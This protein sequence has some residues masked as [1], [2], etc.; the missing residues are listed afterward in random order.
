MTVIT[1]LKHPVFTLQTIFSN[2][3]IQVNPS[4]S[5]LLISVQCLT[6]S[7]SYLASMP[8]SEF[9]TPLSLAAVLANQSH[10]LSS[11]WTSL[12]LICYTYHWWSTQFHPGCHYFSRS[13]FLLLLPSSTFTESIS[14]NMSITPNHLFLISPSNYTHELNNLISGTDALHV[15][16]YKMALS[17]SLAV[18]CL[19]DNIKVLHLVFL[20]YPILSFGQGSSLLWTHTL[21]P[22]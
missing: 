15:W 1:P 4:L 19:A 22:L 7:S 6:T 14:R 11:Q 13:I 10:V 12:L 8:V 17:M 9:L 2:R 18:E 5:F 16:F 20:S 3:Q 21:R